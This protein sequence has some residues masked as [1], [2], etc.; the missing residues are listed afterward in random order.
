MYERISLVICG[1]IIESNEKGCLVN[2][3]QS[4]A[5]SI[6]YVL[7]SH[8]TCPSYVINPDGGQNWVISCCCISTMTID[9]LTIEQLIDFDGTTPKQTISMETL[10]YRE[11]FSA[12]QPY[13]NMINRSRTEPLFLMYRYNIYFLNDILMLVYLHACHLNYLWFYCIMFQI[14]CNC[15]T[16]QHG[17][18]I[19]LMNAITLY[20]Y[21]WNK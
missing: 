20:E 3:K 5:S 18:T 4:G 9:T 21:I 1:K 15:V 19:V 17:R 10:L 13:T 11:T 16:G 12:H 14:K 2:N 8:Q 7:L 6:C